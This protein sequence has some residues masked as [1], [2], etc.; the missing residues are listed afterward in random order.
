M[1]SNQKNLAKSKMKTHTTLVK[2][3]SFFFY[4]IN[5]GSI[6][7]AFINEEEVRKRGLFKMMHGVHV[8]SSKK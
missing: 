6:E 5:N 4:F 1:L 8:H 7:N 2:V 3:S